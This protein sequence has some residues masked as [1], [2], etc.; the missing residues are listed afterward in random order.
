MNLEFLIVFTS[1]GL[2]FATLLYLI[3]TC[4][5]AGSRGSAST[6]FWAKIDGMI[7]RRRETGSSSLTSLESPGPGA[8]ILVEGHERT[9]LPET[10][11]RTGLK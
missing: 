3:M 7:S 9:L 6:G 11:V 10:L 8:L 4:E 1:N 2:V 5:M